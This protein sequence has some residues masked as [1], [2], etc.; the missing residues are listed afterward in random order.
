MATAACLC[1]Q[2]AALPRLRPLL[3][4]GASDLLTALALLGGVSVAPRWRRR[5][6]RG[7]S[8]QFYRLPARRIDATLTWHYR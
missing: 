7:G 6:G 8:R 2:Q 3:H 5:P 1:S 4:R